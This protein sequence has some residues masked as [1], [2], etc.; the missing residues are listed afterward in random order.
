MLGA[1]ERDNA[2]RGAMALCPSPPPPGRRLFIMHCLERQ[3]RG[4][5]G[6]RNF[7]TLAIS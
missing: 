4:M 5:N 3:N 7:E 1:E 6:T 2:P